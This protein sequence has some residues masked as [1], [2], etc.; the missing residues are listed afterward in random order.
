MPLNILQ[1]YLN[2]IVIFF[3]FFLNYQHFYMSRI[4]HFELIETTIQTL[5]I[6]L[7]N[8]YENTHNNLMFHIYI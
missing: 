5:H 3:Q 2:G 4:I 7:I 6:A 1:L 8:I